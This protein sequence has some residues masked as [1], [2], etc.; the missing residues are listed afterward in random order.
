MEP[1][2]SPNTPGNITIVSTLAD[3]R[4]EPVQNRNPRTAAPLPHGD[5]RSPVTETRTTSWPG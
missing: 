3:G 5:D 1:G 2:A 4:D